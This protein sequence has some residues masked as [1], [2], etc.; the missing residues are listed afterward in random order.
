VLNRLHD[1]LEPN[2]V[3]VWVEVSDHSVAWCPCVSHF[4]SIDC[5]VSAGTVA[6]SHPAGTHHADTASLNGK[7]PVDVASNLG[8]VFD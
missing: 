8:V 5:W 7:I 2:G 4:R 1:S 3:E 6:G